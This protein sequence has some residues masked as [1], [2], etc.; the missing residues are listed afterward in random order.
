[1]ID[2]NSLDDKLLKK[3]N[4]IKIGAK[5][6]QIFMKVT[7]EYEKIK[8]FETLGFINMKKINWFKLKDMVDD[9]KKDYKINW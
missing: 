9:M 2:K 8:Y 3:I 5:Q 1:M 4:R 7:F 6:S